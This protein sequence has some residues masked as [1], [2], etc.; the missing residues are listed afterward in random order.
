MI[1]IPLKV[2]QI[3]T[4]LIALGSKKINMS[5]SDPRWVTWCLV[6]VVSYT[7]AVTA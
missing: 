1:Y 7:M 2:K 5:P 6:S 4:H 3:Y